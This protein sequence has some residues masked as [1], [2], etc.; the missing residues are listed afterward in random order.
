MVFNNQDVTDDVNW[1]IDAYA[2]ND[3][4]KMG[5]LFGETLDTHLANQEKLFLY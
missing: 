5:Y 1:I 2:H 3:F 4:R